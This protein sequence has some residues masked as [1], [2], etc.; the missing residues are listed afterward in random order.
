MAPAPAAAA[1]LACHVL[2]IVSI[3]SG[4]GSEIAG[5]HTS[6]YLR[7][8]MTVMGTQCTH[9]AVSMFH[10]HHMM[11]SCNKRNCLPDD[12]DPDFTSKLRYRRASQVKADWMSRGWSAGP[13]AGDD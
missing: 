12:E 7:I 13:G 11:I 10:V 1:A 5:F 4:S 2:W 6:R 3:W 9:N 8:I